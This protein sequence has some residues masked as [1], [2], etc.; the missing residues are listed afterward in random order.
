MCG[1]ARKEK[2]LCKNQ[3]RIQNMYY[4]FTYEQLH[5]SGKTAEM[6][7]LKLQQLIHVFL[8]FFDVSLL[9]KEHHQNY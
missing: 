9:P 1:T 8:K 6:K 5:I 4:Q 7:L 2:H 3:I